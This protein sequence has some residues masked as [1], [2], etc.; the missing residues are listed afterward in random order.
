MNA[1]H[2]LRGVFT[3]VLEPHTLRDPCTRHIRFP[4]HL[5]NHESIQQCTNQTTLDLLYFNQVALPPFHAVNKSPRSKKKRNK[6]QCQ[7]E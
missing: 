2:C 1:M 3:I 7:L 4:F 5:C 6:R